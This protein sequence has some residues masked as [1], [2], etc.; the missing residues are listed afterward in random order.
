MK[1][2]L[3]LLFAV[4]LTALTASAQIYFPFEYNGI[5]Y[6][7]IG[8][9]QVQVVGSGSGQPYQGDIVIPN[10]VFNDDHTYYVTKIGSSAFANCTNLT[11]V[12]FSSIS[13]I[14]SYA[15]MGCTSLTSFTIPDNV[16]TLEWNVFQDCSSLT[17]V[18][19]GTGVTSIR[20]NAFYGCTALTSIYCKAATPPTI[21]S[22]TFD[23]YH[24]SLAKL[25]VPVGKK[26]DY[27]AANYWSTFTN[28]YE[29]DY[30]F[31]KDGLYYTITSSSPL[32][33]KLTYRDTGY[34]CYS[35]N[36]T[37]PST[38]TIAGSYYYNLTYNVTE[39][40][41]NTFRDC[42]DLTQVTIPSSVTVINS[43][44]F[45][46]CTNL[47][48]VTIPSWVYTI[49][50]S[51]FSGC[52]G[53]RSVDIPNSVMTIGQSAFN[54]C[55]NLES[56]T[57]GSGVTSIGYSA[58]GSC[59]DLTRI[60]CKAAT[61]PTIQSG[62]FTSKQYSNAKL[63]VPVGKTSTYR[64]ANYW[65][66]FTN[67]VESDYDFEDNGIYYKITGTSPATVKVTYSDTEYNSYRGD[68]TIPSTVTSG[69]TT[70]HITEIGANA[71]RNCTGLTQV[72][73][74]T[75]VTTIEASAFRDC[76]SLTSVVIPNSVTTIGQTAFYNCSQLSSVVIGSDVTSIGTGAF[77]YCAALTSITCWAATPPNVTSN[78]FGGNQYSNAQLYVPVGQKSAYQ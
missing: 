33:V 48:S 77:N 21:Q 11:S 9:N 34:N 70:Y 58:F 23:G 24:Y 1:R 43:N 76:S 66:D 78:T 4:L 20:E 67:I 18:V 71:F 7:Q 5:N 42:T 13:T 6:V 19:I 36:V 45:R 31:E 46:G 65:S 30:D 29:S 53:L 52:Y 73:I 50:T 56:V 17:N 8:E 60:T 10:M 2:N 39:I 61:P 69:G 64:A 28:I 22:N 25:Y 41:D 15:F 35:G 55:I 12:R 40:G 54:Y 51:A 37:I 14:G 38:V 44:A 16:T 26:I 47:S 68:V 3:L 72:K 27:Q 63:V 32:T 62:T 49:G 75:S 74:P 59:V 57:I